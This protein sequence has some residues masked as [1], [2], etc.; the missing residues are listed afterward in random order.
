MT[1][2]RFKFPSQILPVELSS[3]LRT[4][5]IEL[6]FDDDFLALTN[7]SKQL[8]TEADLLLDFVRPIAERSLADSRSEYMR[9]AAEKTLREISDYEEFLQTKMA[10][11][12]MN[13]FPLQ[14]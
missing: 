10:E 8:S 9:K 11:V 7:C 2:E 6:T 14:K 13:R 4:I 12:S 5:L 1:Y 3:Y